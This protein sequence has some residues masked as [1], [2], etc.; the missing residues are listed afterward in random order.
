LRER[1]KRKEIK[2]KDWFA[3][4]KKVW[5]LGFLALGSFTNKLQLGYI[6]SPGSAKYFLF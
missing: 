4:Y 5:A 2:K 1:K 3:V 6:F